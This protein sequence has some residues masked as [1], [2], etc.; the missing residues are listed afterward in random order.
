MLR[1]SKKKVA[2]EEFYGTKT[3]EIWDINVEK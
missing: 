1:F 2:E 3:N